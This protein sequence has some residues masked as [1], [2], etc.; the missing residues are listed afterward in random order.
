M[1]NTYIQSC[2]LSCVVD[3]TYCLVKWGQ[4]RLALL[5]GS[6]RVHYMGLYQVVYSNIFDSGALHPRTI[7][8][9]AF[10]HQLFFMYSFTACTI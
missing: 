10:I 8:V 1:C 4:E 7:H 5:I 6:Q 2:S 9:H 3:G